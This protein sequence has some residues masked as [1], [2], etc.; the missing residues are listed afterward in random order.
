MQT[1][2]Y[3][4]IP[5][6]WKLENI[7]LTSYSS[8][9]KILIRF[10]AISDHGNNLYVDDINISN[11]PLVIEDPILFDKVTVY[12]NPTNGLMN[13]FIPSS[14]HATDISICNLLGEEMISSAITNTSQVSLDVS[15]QGN[16]MY[17]VKVISEKGMEM[18]PFV[19]QR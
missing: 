9:S 8:F 15:S 2:P 1:P 12:P 11:T 17:F 18:V 5:T 7:D 6:D 4:P 19:L 14:Q 3:L 16:G 13:V 10:I